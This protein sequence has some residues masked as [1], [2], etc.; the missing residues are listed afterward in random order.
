MVHVNSLAQAVAGVGAAADQWRALA[1][2]LGRW[3][4]STTAAIAATAAVA[5]LLLLAFQ[6]V[7]SHVERQGALRRQ[8]QTEHVQA[9]WRCRALGDAQARQAC[10]AQLVPVWPA[11]G[12]QPPLRPTA[13]R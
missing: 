3:R 1:R 13:P 11:G 12:A 4:I 8:A 6:Q 10:L 5:G 2:A 9:S 7:V